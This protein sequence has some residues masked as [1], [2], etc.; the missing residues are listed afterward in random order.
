[1]KRNFKKII[2][3]LICTSVILTLLS[4]TV[5]A[6]SAQTHWSGVDSTGA[7]VVGESCPIEV[8]KEVLTLDALE[9]PTNHYGTVEEYLTYTGKVTA[10]YTFYNPTDLTVTATLAFPFGTQPDYARLKYDNATYSYISADTEK[11][12]ITVNGEAV[13]KEIRYTLNPSGG[14]FKLSNDLPRLSDIYI[15]DDFYS[16]VMT[17]T[18]YTY[19]VGG[20]NKEGQI[21]EVK[22]RAVDAAFDWDGGDGKTRIYCPHQSGF[23]RQKDGGGK[24]GAMVDNGDILVVYAIGNPISAPLEW[25]CYECGDVEDGK[26]IEGIVSLINTE[27]MTLEDLALEKWNEDTGVSKVDWYNAVIAAFTEGGKGYAEYNYIGNFYYGSYTS[28]EKFASSLMRWYQYEIMIEPKTSITNTVT[29]PIYPEID[30]RYRPAI[31]N[32]TYL[33]SPASTWASF[34]E[35]EIVINTPFYIT[36]NTIDGFTKTDNGY[37]YKQNGLPSSELEFTLCTDKNP[38]YRSYGGVLINGIRIET[39]IFIA[40]I[41]VVAFVGVAVFVV[42]RKKNTGN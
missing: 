35:L 5:S 26:E 33:L 20:E 42:R 13:D 7:I 18:K 28:T 39:L 31:Y 12:G 9:L 16:P 30:A 2:C 29:A 17:V 32:Y 34:G 6:N 10:E 36:D 4:M 8:T 14:S 22:Y 38:T 21:D 19:I 41:V 40:A 25:N 1:M 37:T 27:T 15:E 23:Y 24:F 11:Y 3:S